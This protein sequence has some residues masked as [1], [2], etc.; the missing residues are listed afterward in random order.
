MFYGLVRR[1]ARQAG[2]SKACVPSGLTPG[3]HMKWYLRVKS[4]ADLLVSF[5]DWLGGWGCGAF[6]LPVFKKNCVTIILLGL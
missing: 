4:K 6:Y 2:Q 1:N 5:M 3:C